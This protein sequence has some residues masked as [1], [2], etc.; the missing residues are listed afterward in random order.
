MSQ[1]TPVSVEP[2]SNNSNLYVI[3]VTILLVIA[4][5][6]CI[7]R[8]YTRLTRTKRLYLD[9]WFIVV[10]EPLSLINACL[11]YA[12][13]S[14]GW[15]RPFMTL[16]EAD[17][18]TTMKL[19]FALQTTWIFTLCFVRLSVACSLLRFGTDL[20]WRYTLY[21]L[22]GLQVAISSSW[23]V[24]QFGQC[25]PISSNWE[26]V[27]DVKC[28]NL[29][30]I[31]NYGWTI[32]GVYVIM[33]LILSLMPIK[34]I[35][36]LNRPRNEKVLISLLMALG[37]LATAVA[38]AK[39]TTFKNFGTG[40]PMQATIPPSMYA[41]LEEVVGIIA[42]SL[43]CLKAPVQNLLKKLGVLQTRQL[44]RPSFVNTAITFDE[45]SRQ[46]EQRSD[47]DGSFPSL[48][49]SVHMD[50]VSVKPSSS[51]SNTRDRSHERKEKREVV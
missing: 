13:I 17:Y 1:S 10:A 3:P 16:S 49:D 29:Q 43:P 41:K 5:I 24:I 35:R 31:I 48:K 37:L 45:P 25:K 36:T 47:R 50:Y 22:M 39:M 12:A 9:D 28:W 42:S 6:L 14:H 30:A 34:L 23:V 44:S 11:A 15:G 18:K 20:W 21:I 32:A 8:F 4:L 33:D 26:H 27:K 19:Q 46:G 40:D 7:V 51:G 2:N 38:A